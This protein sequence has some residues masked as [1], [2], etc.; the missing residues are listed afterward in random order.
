MLVKPTTMK[1]LS[2]ITTMRY[3]RAL[4]IDEQSRLTNVYSPQY[5]ALTKLYKW[6]SKNIPDKRL[7]DK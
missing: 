1:E 2:E 4:I 6:V 3:I 5:R 7:H